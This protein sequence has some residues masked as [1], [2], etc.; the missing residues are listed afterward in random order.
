MGHRKVAVMVT[1][2]RRVT[3]QRR[4]TVRPKVMVLHRAMHRHRVM[5]RAVI[6]VRRP[7]IITDIE[8]LLSDPFRN[9]PIS[10]GYEKGDPI[11]A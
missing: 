10:Y 7:A 5:A 11:T 8:R 2:R 9:R 3:A 4:V 6:T 1:V